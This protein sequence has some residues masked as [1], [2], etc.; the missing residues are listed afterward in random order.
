MLG[1]LPARI[2]GSSLPLGNAAADKEE[3]QLGAPRIQAN[4]R[5]KSKD[6]RAKK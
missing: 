4:S 2:L 1:Y 5:A 6:Q 3:T